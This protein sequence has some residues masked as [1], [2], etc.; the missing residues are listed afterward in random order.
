MRKEEV[1]EKENK[2]G[3][4]EGNKEAGNEEE[5][6]DAIVTATQLQPLLSYNQHSVCR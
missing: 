4:K 2:E 5:N 1:G 6:E 3:N